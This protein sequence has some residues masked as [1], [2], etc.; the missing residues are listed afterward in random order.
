[1]ENNKNNEIDLIGILRSLWK[2]RLNILTYGSFGA[3][4][5]LIIAFSIPK[6][7]TSSVTVAPETQTK[8][9]GGSA[10][11]LANMIGFS[12][13]NSIDGINEGLYGE[14]VS[15]SPFLLE[16]SD[17]KV[18]VDGDSIFF[19][20]Y[21]LERQKQPWWGYVIQTPFY[22][23]DY[24]RSLFKDNIDT[25]TIKNSPKI[26]Y[27]FCEKMNKRI[28]LKRNEEQGLISIY[29]TFQEPEIAKLI[30]DSLLS[31]LQTYITNYKTAKTRGNLFSNEKMLS[32][33]KEKYLQIDNE[34]ADA[35]DKNRGLATQTSMIKLERLQSERTLAFQVYSQ[36]ALQVESDRV[37]LQEN[38]PIIT[39]IEP[40][41]FPIK[42]S[43]PNK[44][45]IIFLCIIMSCFIVIIK[46]I[47]SFL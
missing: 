22:I 29:S 26:Q 46:V 27:D 17:V 6:E 39:I 45:L 10:G 43:S 19:S 42:A 16:F 24:T 23:L 47:K 25:L 33:A 31:K 15:S 12:S 20:E 30:N 2:Q 21:I 18:V 13:N 11:A 36:L 40:V 34:Y 41:T 1:M 5:G 38:I 3:I 8:L 9:L 28:Y 35:V 7:Y 32:D 44:L 4:F 37:K 14:V